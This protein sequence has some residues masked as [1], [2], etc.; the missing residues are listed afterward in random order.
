MVLVMLGTLIASAAFFFGLALADALVARTPR[1]GAL[2]GA[3]VLP[4]DKA[5]RNHR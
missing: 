3:T 2:E 5:D 1:D 4:V